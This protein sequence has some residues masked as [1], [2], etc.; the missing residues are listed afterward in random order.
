MLLRQSSRNILK[1]V[2]EQT[3]FPVQVLDDPKLPT[4]ATVRIARDTIPAHVITYKPV[5]GEQPDY[6]IAYQCGFILRHFANPSHLRVDIG[7]SQQG[8]SEVHKAVM[9]SGGPAQRYRLNQSQAAQLQ[10]Q[11][12]GGLIIHLRSAPVGMRV[13]QWIKQ[14]YPEF[15]ELQRAQVLRE[16]DLNREVLRREFKEM[17]PE[18]VYRPTLAINAAF[19]LFWAKQFGDPDLQAGYQSGR[20]ERDGQALFDIWQETSVEAEYDCVLVDAW[21]RKLGLA[22]WYEWVPYQPPA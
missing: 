17:T 9:A 10:A 7:S 16:L 20:T 22:D 18:Q 5:T 4:M 15:A 19:A 6:L 1:L 12:L 14:E 11:L 13:G 8:R 2:E 21:G 3:G